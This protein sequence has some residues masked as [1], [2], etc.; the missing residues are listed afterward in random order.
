MSGVQLSDNLIEDI[1][2][3]LQQH[4]STAAD[5][6]VAVQYMA[7]SVGYFMSALPDGQF[8]KKEVLSQLAD[9]TFQVFDQMESD[10]KPKEEAYGVWKP[11]N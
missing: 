6:L 5:D 9:F 2:K 1:K 3:V 4:D 8:D 7:A 11:E 10:K